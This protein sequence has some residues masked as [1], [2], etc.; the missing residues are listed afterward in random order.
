MNKFGITLTALGS[1]IATPILAAD[2]ALKAPPPPPAPVANWTG[3]YVG[4]NGGWIGSEDTHID[5]TA[6]QTA[7]GGLLTAI[8]IGA[9]PNSI[10]T[11]NNGGLVGGTLGYNW[12]VTP[13]W[14]VGVEGDIDWV[15][16]KDHTAVGPFT[17]VDPTITTVSTQ[18]EWLST[19]RGRLGY[20]PA[21]N[22][23]LYVTGGL[24]VGEHRLG[25]AAF[26]PTVVPVLNAASTT[27]S[28]STGWTI[29]GGL[30]WK[31]APQWSVKAEY[32]W[33]DLGN[34][35]STINYNFPGV[36]SSLTAHVHN[37]SYNIARAGINYTF[38]G[39][40]ARY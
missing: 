11:T 16:A 17:A 4:V 8:G 18:V 3:F 32:L 33:V 35:N 26:S 27:Q 30:E 28:T 12:Q 34:L 9:I 25:I 20:T 10:G 29:G 22:A 15:S 23:L 13:L 36:T 7:P 24:A 38:G 1:L 37:D 5:N 39:P 6:T 31:V 19:V 40:A 21:A 2:L 14:L